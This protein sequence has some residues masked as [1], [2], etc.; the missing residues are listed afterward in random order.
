MCSTAAQVAQTQANS[1]FCCASQQERGLLHVTSERRAPAL[2][3]GKPALLGDPHPLLIVQLLLRAV[4]RRLPLCHEQKLRA[5]V[6]MH[7]LSGGSNQ[8]TLCAV[9]SRGI[10]VEPFE[11]E[12]ALAV[13]G[14]LAG[15]VQAT[16]CATCRARGGTHATERSSAAGAR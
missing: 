11:T 1:M 7:V 15:C 4:R 3:H 16:D 5:A 9:G 6:E 8:R 10:Q 13:G 14:E 12:H 2:A